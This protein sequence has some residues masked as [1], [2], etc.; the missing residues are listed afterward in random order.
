MSWKMS[1]PLG[2]NKDEPLPDIVHGLA[3]EGGY[4]IPGNPP[5][6][7]GDSR[8]RSDKPTESLRNAIALIFSLNES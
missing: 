1:Q 7:G 4:I 5:T 3:H 6:W 2:L 8:Q